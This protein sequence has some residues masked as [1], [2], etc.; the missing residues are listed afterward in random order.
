MASVLGWWLRDVVL[1]GPEIDAPM[2]DLLV[3]DSAPTG[4]IALS[5]WLPAHA[6]EL[7]VRYANE[8]A[9][10]RDRATAYASL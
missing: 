6:A 4:S 3:T 2:D 8:L 1:T 10:R 5:E 7:G 9:R